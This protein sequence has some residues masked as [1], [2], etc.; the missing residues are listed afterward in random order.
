MTIGIIGAM[1][2]EV[3]KLR[4]LMNVIATK[5]V[6]GIEFYMGSLPDCS[7][8]IVLVRSGIGKVNA[9][10]CAQVL[11]DLFAVDMVINLGVA[12]AINPSLNIGDVVISSEALYHDFDT[13]AL[14]DAPG[15][16][17]RMDTSVFPASEEL[18]ELAKQSVEELGVN[19][20]VGRI[21]SGDKF[22]A[23]VYDKAMITQLFGADCCEMEGAAIAH[24]CFLNKIPFVVLRV[25]S[26]SA[27]NDSNI[28]YPAFFK[29]AADFGAAVLQ[30]MLKKI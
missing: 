21:A 26:D 6:I 1:E 3:S 5:Q 22:I 12:G 18:I 27:N 8:S 25:I 16:I 23:S 24:T 9:A 11:V 14:G 2:E 4:S 15:Y 19:Y 28:D 30:S 17:S 13:T 20:I 7:H 29:E 10:L